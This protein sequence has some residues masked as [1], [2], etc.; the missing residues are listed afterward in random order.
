MKVGNGQCTSLAVEAL[1][2]AGARGMGRDFPKRGDYVWGEQVAL[3]EY[4]HRAV[5]GLESLTKVKPGHIIQFRNARLA[6]RGPAGGT[7]GMTT[8]RQSSPR[9]IRQIRC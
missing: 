1:A 3:L 9:S 2:A 4:D 8:T 5:A 7:Y 6:G